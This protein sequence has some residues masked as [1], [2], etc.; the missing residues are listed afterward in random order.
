ML[1]I[2]TQIPTSLRAKFVWNVKSLA[3]I[4][5]IPSK[6]LDPLSLTPLNTSSMPSSRVFKANQQ[7]ASK[8][9]SFLPASGF[10]LL[11]LARSNQL[12]KDL[13]RRRR[14]GLFC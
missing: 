3:N 12:N 4:G 13:E 1:E 7:F 11:Q 6:S 2:Q 14:Y 10:E 8:F 5:L 9:Y